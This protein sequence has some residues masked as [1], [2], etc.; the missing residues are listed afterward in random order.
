[1]RAYALRWPLHTSRSRQ[2]VPDWPRVLDCSELGLRPTGRMCRSE[3]H[4]ARLLEP[5]RASSSSGPSTASLLRLCKALYFLNGFSAS[6]FGRFATIFYVDVAKLS[7]KQIGI[8]EGAQPV[9]GMVGQQLIGWISDRLQRKKI[10]S[11]VS[12]CITT[13]VLLLLMW[14]RV[15]CCMERILAVM[16]TVAFFSV[17]AGVL[18]SYT[19]D[20]LGDARRGEYGRYRLWLAVS[21]G[22]GNVAMGVVAQINFN[23]NFLAFAVL[24]VL[25]I[26]L[27]GCALPARTHAEQRLVAKAKEALQRSACEPRVGEPSGC[28]ASSSGADVQSAPVAAFAVLRGALCRARMLAFLLELIAIGFGFTLVEKFIFVYAMKDL[29]ATPSLCGYSVGVTVIFEIPIFAYGAA[30]LTILGHD[31][32]IW[33]S[34]ASYVCRVI[35]YT[36]LTPQTVWYLLALEPFHGIT[37]ALAWTAAVDK[38]K[39]EWP[40]E[41]QTTGMLLLNTCMWSIGRTTGSLFG[42]FYYQ[43]GSLLGETGGKALYLAAGFGGLAVLTLHAIVSLLLKACGL[44]ALHTPPQQQQPDPPPE[45]TPPLN[46]EETSN[47]GEA[48]SDAIN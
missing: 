40:V 33:L 9:A 28:D 34:L 7:A 38:M 12:Q 1:M 14:P 36:R 18:D 30:L 39:V 8:V 13:S 11:L 25:C 19:L 15:A 20:L 44:R 16:A 3:G 41:W 47:A 10:I 29:G 31:L 48:C 5:E 17:G 24:N 27:M 45:S 42:G 35:G 32:M 37:Y 43:H 23:Y 2:M 21:W 46:A 4:A 22:V 6:S 26:L